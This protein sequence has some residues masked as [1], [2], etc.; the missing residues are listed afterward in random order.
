MSPLARVWPCPKPPA[1]SKSLAISAWSQPMKLRA[2]AI[3]IAT[4][5]PAVEPTPAESATAPMKA[6]MVDVLSA[7]MVTAPAF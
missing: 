4:P 6:S 1:V 5:M 7:V 2:T 3:P